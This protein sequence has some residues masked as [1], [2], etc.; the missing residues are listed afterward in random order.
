MSSPP[1]TATLLAPSSPPLP[2]PPVGTLPNPG[3][4]TRR[5]TWYRLLTVGIA[6]VFVVSQAVLGFLAS[7]NVGIV[8]QTCSGLLSVILLV[9]GWYESSPPPSWQWFFQTNWDSQKDA[10]SHFRCRIA[11]ALK[12]LMTIETANLFVSF[13]AVVLAVFFAVYQIHASLLLMQLRRFIWPLLLAMPILLALGQVVMKR[14]INV[15]ATMY[16]LQACVFLMLICVIVAAAVLGGTSV[17]INRSFHQQREQQDETSKFLRGLAQHWQDVLAGSN[18]DEETLREDWNRLKNLV[19]GIQPATNY[20]QTVLLTFQCAEAMNEVLAMQSFLSM[21]KV[22]RQHW[23]KK[24]PDVDI[25]D[26]PRTSHLSP[27][28]PR[29]SSDNFEEGNG[30][31]GDRSW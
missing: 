24:D 27:P 16:R 15:Q 28:D 22:E 26:L 8:V 11:A 25:D 5:V 10:I 7:T 23:P 21:T 13:V 30:V 3:P 17:T 9:A 31:E 14:K 18:G 20:E 19:D 6:T 2:V 29:S 12:P 4:R 1:S